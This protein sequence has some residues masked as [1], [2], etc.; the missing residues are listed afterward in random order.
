MKNYGIN[1][2]ISYLKYWNINNLC[3]YAMLKKL[4]VAGFKRLEE[5]SQFT[6]DYIK[7]L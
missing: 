3:G 7:K 4:P 5:T 2:K 1:K 6:G